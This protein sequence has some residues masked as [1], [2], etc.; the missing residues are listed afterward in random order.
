MHLLLR[1]AATAAILLPLAVAPVSA[2]N[3]RGAFGIYGGGVWF[4]DLNSDGGFD[5]GDIIFED[6]VIFDDLL[7]ILFLLDG[8][9]D[10]SLKSGW[11]VGTQLEYWFGNGR[12]G[13]RANGSYTERPFDLDGDFFNGIIDIIDDDDIIIDDFF[14]DFN[15]DFGDVNVWFLDGDLMFRILR[16][17]RNRTFAP[18][19]T[20][21]AGAVIYNPAGDAPIFIPAANAIFGDFEFVDFDDDDEFDI[22]ELSGDND[23][24]EFALVFGIGTDI[25]PRNFRLGSVG[26]GL[27]LEL[28][29]HYVFDSPAKPIFGNDDF[30]GVHNVRLTAGIHALFGR[31]FPEPVAIVT[32]PAPPPPPPPPAEER[33]TVCVIDPQT[34]EIREVSAIYRPSTGDTLVMMNGDRVDLE[35]AYPTTAPVYAR[36]ASWFIAGQPL[37]IDVMG[38]RYEWVTF[39]GTR[40]IDPDD[41]VL[42]GR[43]NGLPVYAD[44]DDVMT[45][46]G[47]LNGNAELEDVMERDA[48]VREV[49]DNL[50]VV[51]VAVDIN[52]VFQPLRR[53]EEVRKVRG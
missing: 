3:Y 36:N 30:D 21:G 11:I 26:L 47:R 39:G 37:A 38:Q 17:E 34:G 50:D 40:I 15:D 33:I 23:E 45:V 2:Q 28:V 41:L 29:D 6:D 5:F 16:P 42:L 1:A 4:S 7:D 31:L 14:F 20:L 27:R 53:L 51:Y 44:A 52:C 8:P 12:F 48:E 13:L 32:P 10:L 19:L 24:T 18:Y 9:A 43:V 35:T 49:V 46:R 22:I 25:L